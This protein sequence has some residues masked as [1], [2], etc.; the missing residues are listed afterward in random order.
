MR[1]SSQTFHSLRGASLA[2]LAVALMAAGPCQFGERKAEA[3]AA[4][5]AE[6]E[7]LQERL[8]QALAAEAEANRAAAEALE[9]REALLEA[10]EEQ[11]E[12]QQTLAAERSR[13]AAEAARLRQREQELAIREK[14]L[15]N[16]EAN[17]SFQEQEL[18]D[19]ET[20][21][22]ELLAMPEEEPD[23]AEVANDGRAEPSEIAGDDGL[24]PEVEPGAEAARVAAALE[25]GRLF[26]VEVLETLTSRDS[27]VGD[28][29]SARLV[30]DLT[31]EDGTLVVP[32]GAEVIGRVSRVQPLKKVGG[33]ASLEVEFTH[34]ILSP[35]DSIAITASFVEFGVDKRKD[36]KRI[37]G[38]AI[39]GAILG[40]VLGGD[41]EAVIAGAAAG[42]AAATVAAARAKGQ[43][44][45]IPAG[46]MAALQLEEVVTVDVEVK[47][48][49]G[50]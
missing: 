42:S 31:A 4:A 32:A 37:A 46:T 27:R 22:E 40:H 30:Q 35:T 34:I 20:E 43:D 47:G 5:R 6:Q 28:T 3:E 48:P 23:A 12:L 10:R 41:T 45:E 9:E 36:K 13:L 14:E 50:G 39:V 26:E 29:F 1:S 8:E 11:L 21:L 7:A 16:F 44:A 2:L 49:A 18:S 25:P 33:R 19:R 38:A 17:L 24:D 15:E